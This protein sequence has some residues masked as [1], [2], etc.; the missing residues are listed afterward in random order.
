[1]AER[2]PYIHLS[3]WYHCT[4]GVRPGTPYA[5]G[6]PCRFVAQDI[7]EPREPYLNLRT[8][9][10]TSDTDLAGPAVA[11][12]THYVYML[13]GEA[14][15]VEFAHLPGIYFVVLLIERVNVIPNPYW[16]H[17]IAPVWW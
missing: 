6:E 15:Q 13:W 2:A 17:W 10:M 7:I 3:D 8:A 1:M 9:W 11:P 16:R 14:D 12:L 5:T 4:G